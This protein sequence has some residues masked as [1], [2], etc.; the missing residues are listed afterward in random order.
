[1]NPA[2]IAKRFTADG[3]QRIDVMFT[4]DFGTIDDGVVEVGV[5]YLHSDP[6]HF[7]VQSPDKF[8][9]E[10]GWVVREIAQEDRTVRKSMFAMPRRWFTGRRAL[11]TR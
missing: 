8:A 3:V 7:L 4:S 5:Q 1:M 9:T 2:T 11:S 10:D 6:R